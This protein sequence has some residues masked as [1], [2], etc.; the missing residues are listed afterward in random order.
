MNDMA[1]L[2]RKRSCRANSPPSPSPL[3]CPQ[4]VLLRPLRPPAAPCPWRGRSAAGAWPSPARCPAP[5]ARAA[6]DGTA[7]GPC[8]RS[9][10]TARSS[11]PS[12]SCPSRA[13][14]A[15]PSRRRPGTPAPRCAARSV[16]ARLRPR[17]PRRPAREVAAH[18]EPEGFA[19]I[20]RQPLAHR[21]IRQRVQGARAEMRQ[22][23]F[24]EARRR[25][26]HSREVDGRNE[27]VERRHRL[28][29]IG[30]A[31]A[32]QQ[33]ADRQRLDAPLAQLADRQRAGAL[34]QAATG[35][36]DQQRQMGEH[37]EPAPSASNIW[38]CAPV[39]VTWSSPRITWRDAE[40]DVVDHRGEAVEVGAVGAHQHR[41]A[42]ARLVDMLRP[43]HQ[44][45][46]AHLLGRELEAPMRPAALALEPRPRRR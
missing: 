23:L 1:P 32:R 9:Q 33:R 2:Y 4:H 8:G 21:R 6:A 13:P 45:R 7:P 38:I 24:R 28:D 26:S 25:T 27:R 11:R 37:R 16:R 17:S 29:R 42:L 34:A 5:S 3:S 44:V 19:Q 46:P 30:R 41:I 15:A 36:I 35:R 10:P 20:R 22:L 43:A 18:R 40:V 31:Q 39:L 14:T 12:R